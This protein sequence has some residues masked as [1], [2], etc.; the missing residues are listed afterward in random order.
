MINCELELRFGGAARRALLGRIIKAGLPFAVTPEKFYDD[1]A[2]GV[3]A[4]WREMFL[5]PKTPLKE[6]DHVPL[7]QSPP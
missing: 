3:L 5:C 1:L 2:L 7:K 6:N 4:P